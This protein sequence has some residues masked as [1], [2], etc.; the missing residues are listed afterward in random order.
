MKTLKK[1]S[2]MPVYC[3][4]I[5]DKSEMEFGKIYISN[6]S[7]TASHLCLCGCGHEASISI[8]SNGWKLED[9]G[10]KITVSPSLQHLFRCRSHYIIQNGNG[11]FV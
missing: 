4:F 8:G 10:G 3:K 5:P 6:E 7:E 11:N 2:V 9:N 1:V